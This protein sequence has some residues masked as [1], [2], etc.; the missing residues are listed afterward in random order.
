MS[1]TGQK[2]H[3]RT[4]SIIQGNTN[5]SSENL[6]A[7]SKQHPSVTRSQHQQ[8]NQY[9]PLIDTKS[10]TSNNNHQNV[11]GNTG[12]LNNIKNNTSNGS[13]KSISNLSNYLAVIPE[14][15]SFASPPPTPSKQKTHELFSGKS[16]S[17]T[18]D[19]FNVIQVAALYNIKNVLFTLIFFGALVVFLGSLMGIG[20]FDDEDIHYHNNAMSKKQ[21]EHLQQPPTHFTSSPIISDPAAHEKSESRNTKH[22]QEGLL[23]GSNNDNSPAGQSNKVD[24]SNSN[25]D[26]NNN[27]DTQLS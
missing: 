5:G 19:N 9:L 17:S 1:A 25:K 11:N 23:K 8:Q 21:Q 27:N 16:K 4:L 18:T 22:D 13:I 24:V 7:T 15:L 26:H 10:K 20:P 12:I 6:I 3:R 2:A 14:K